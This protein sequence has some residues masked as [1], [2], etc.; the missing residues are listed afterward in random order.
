MHNKPVNI[1]DSTL[2][3][4]ASEDTALVEWEV[5]SRAAGA[6][7][8]MTAYTEDSKMK[9]SWQD[10]EGAEEDAILGLALLVQTI[11]VC[12]RSDCTRGNTNEDNKT[13]KT[14]EAAQD[15][16]EDEGELLD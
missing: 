9:D 6:G 5:P 15:G 11:V 4:T 1:L 14:L 13:H 3:N 7:N 8:N 16:P 10:K 2:A 12:S